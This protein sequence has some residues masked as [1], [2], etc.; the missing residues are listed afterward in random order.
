MKQSISVEQLEVL[1]FITYDKIH[2]LFKHND[3]YKEKLA[4]KITIGKMIEILEQDSEILIP[5]LETYIGAV[6]GWV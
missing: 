3:G 4:S 1:D 6:G 5:T 2:V